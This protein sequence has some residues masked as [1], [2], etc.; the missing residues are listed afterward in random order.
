MHEVL[1]EVQAVE[2]K[3]DEFTH[4]WDQSYILEIDQALD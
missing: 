1:H 2:K 3:Q 4:I